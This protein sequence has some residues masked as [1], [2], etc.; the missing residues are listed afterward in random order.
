MPTKLNKTIS[1]WSPNTIYIAI[2]TLVYQDFKNY[3]CFA[4]LYSETGSHYVARVGLGFVALP[5]LPR[6][7]LYINY[8]GVYDLTQTHWNF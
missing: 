5:S 7:I 2:F 8:I 6:A 4:L 1:S 3:F